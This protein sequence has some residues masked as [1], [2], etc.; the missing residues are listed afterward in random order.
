M[1]NRQKLLVTVAASAVVL[2]VLFVGYA[3]V[4]SPLV[5]A[6]DR[7]SQV[8]DELKKVQDDLKDQN[9]QAKTIVKLSP[10]LEQWAK[11]SLPPRDPSLRKE[12]VSAED[13]KN[14]HLSQ[15]KTEY[16]RYL[17]GLLRESGMKA[18]TIKIVE[19]AADKKFL[20]PPPKAKGAAPQYHSLAFGVSATGPQAAVYRALRDF[21]K[22]NL[23]HQ[24]RGLTVAVPN[25]KG[26]EKPDPKT[27]ELS[28]VVEALIV[29]GAED[30]TGIWPKTLAKSPRVLAEPDRDY[31]LLSKR[32]LF[33]G[34]ASPPPPPPVRTVR[35]TPPPPPAPSRPK[36]NE[37]ERLETLE[38][39]KVTML[40]WSPTRQR[41]EAT[42]YDQAQGKGDEI[43]VDMR[44]YKTFTI[45]SENENAIL[46][47][48]VVKIDEEQMIFQAEG[49]YFRA[50]LG[51][52][53]HTVWKEPLP[54]SEVRKLGL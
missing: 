23:L 39:V 43:K 28:M 37:K 52:F 38:W 20:P 17:S 54:T 6:W 13:Q 50:R 27:L 48:R 5:D 25:A 16:E 53:L 15:L 1:T 7:R 51:D 26:R 21:H 33:T 34:L 29:Q 3:F 47:A 18:E 12:G 9:G 35:P 4:Y 36:I 40:A 41:W 46:Q 42:L 11:L 32:S 30:R 49:K 2:G 10:R 24:V 14:R 45:Y 19:R 22:T 8:D 31:N 44:L